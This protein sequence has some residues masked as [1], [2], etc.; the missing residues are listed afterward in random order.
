MKKPLKIK[1]VDFHEGFQPETTFLWSRLWEQYDVQLS[2][3]PDWIVFSV[4]GSEHLAY[5]HCVKIFWTGENQAPDFNLCDYAIGFEHLQFE[6]RYLRLPLWTL[7]PTD[8]QAMLT[9][10]QH[11][12]IRQKTGFCSFVYSNSNASP[13]RQEFYDALTRYQPIHSGGRFLNNT[14]G[15]VADKLAFQQQHKFAIAFENTSH[16]GYTTEKLVQAFAAQT[17]P[18]Y[19]GDPRVTDDFN[20]EA[21]IN[22]HDY[23]DWNAVVERVRQINEDE[24]LW[25]QIVSQPALRNMHLAEEYMAQADCFL[26]HIFD[27]KP[28]AA[29]RYSR[30]Y[31]TLKQLRIRQRE[32]RAYKRSLFGL[33][34]C[35]FRKNFYPLA[36]RNARLWNATQTLMRTLKM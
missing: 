2:E 10:H 29:R 21:F 30:D 14:G 20:P 32:H 11:P 23:A 5:N 34:H 17:I 31:W 6:D 26:R 13:A 12:E 24:E 16:A 36:R 7:Y 3:T 35:V 27:Q 28:T 18:I 9:K 8:V 19:W 25:Q 1:F 33:L 22:C 15:P 4:F